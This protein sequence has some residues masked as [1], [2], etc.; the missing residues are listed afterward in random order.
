M[1]SYVPQHAKKRLRLHRLE[2][3]LLRSIRCSDGI[4]FQLELAE[5]VRLARIRTLRAECE[6]I[7]PN[8]KNHVG[9]LEAIESHIASLSEVS[10][11]LILSEFKIKEFGMKT[12]L[13]DS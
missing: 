11:E 4:D 12:K 10:S 6:K 7:K 5:K 8:A 2:E 1:A 3:D 9:Q 13:A